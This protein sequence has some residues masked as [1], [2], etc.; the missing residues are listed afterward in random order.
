MRTVRVSVF[1]A[2]SRDTLPTQLWFGGRPV[3]RREFVKFAAGVLLAAPFAARAQQKAIPVVGFLSPRAVV[4]NSSIEAFLRGLRELGYVE[5]Q[6]I[7]VELRSSDGEN[8]RLPA[9]AAELAALKPN[10]IVTNGE[11]A[12]RAA[13]DAGGTIPI[14]MGVVGD[15]V[16]AGFAQSLAHPGGNLT[17]LTNLGEGLVAKRLELLLETVPTHGWTCAALVER[18]WLI[19]RHV[20]RTVPGL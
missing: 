1:P 7:I 9:L 16:A 6:N 10:V 15:P 20:F 8:K 4:E 19:R 18:H 12:I 13:K 14:V 2:A 17:G 11:P 3:R 5:G